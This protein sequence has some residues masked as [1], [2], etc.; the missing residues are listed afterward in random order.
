MPTLI[1][2]FF[3]SIVSGCLS[4]VIPIIST[5]I[6]IFTGSAD[7]FPEYGRHPDLVLGAVIGALCIVDFG[8]RST[9]TCFAFVLTLQ[10]QGINQADYRAG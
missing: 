9:K 7:I 2:P 1:V 10:A 4:V 3:A 6:G 5:P 8:A